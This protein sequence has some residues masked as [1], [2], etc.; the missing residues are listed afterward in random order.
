LIVFS[1]TVLCLLWR[2]HLEVDSHPSLWN[3]L[4]AGLFSLQLFVLT[5][6]T[7]GI[8]LSDALGT[9]GCG[10][11][12]YAMIWVFTLHEREPGLRPLATAALLLSLGF[13]AKPALVISCALLSLVIFLNQRRKFGGVLGSTLLLFTPTVLC[14]FP[15]FALA[16]LAPDPF[17]DVAWKML[18]MNN[19]SPPVIGIPDPVAW[20]GLASSL[21]FSLSALASRLIERRTGISDVAYILVL[22]LVVTAGLQ[23][24]MPDPLSSTDFSMVVYAGAGCLLALTPPC[25]LLTRLMVAGLSGVALLTWQWW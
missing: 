24:W 9:L 21:W 20:G 1:V 4:L 3:W 22:E 8:P 18:R 16:T 14:L 25:R 11:F 23:P 10:V 19:G 12:I 5:L 7:P 13:I 17:H 6:H 2:F 15:L